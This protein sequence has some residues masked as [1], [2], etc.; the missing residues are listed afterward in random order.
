MCNQAGN[1]EIIAISGLISGNIS[2]NIS[3]NVLVY[4]S[5]PQL[6]RFILG[7]NCR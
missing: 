4:A 6:V 3:E 2:L 5:L 1:S 7:V